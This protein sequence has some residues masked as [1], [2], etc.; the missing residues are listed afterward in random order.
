M[1]AAFGT[2]LTIGGV[3]V[4]ELTSISGS[5]LSM[6]TVD[7]SHHD[8]ADRAREFVAGMIDGGE[9]TMEG[10]LGA[11]HVGLFTGGGPLDCV[12]T[13]PGTAPLLTWAFYG[14]VTAMNCDAPYEGK[15]GF[16]ATM[17]VTGLAVLGAAPVPMA[18]EAAG[19]TTA[20]D[21]T[22]RFSKTIDDTNLVFGDFSYTVNA[23][24]DQSFSAATTLA[25]ERYVE[26]IPAGTNI[27]PGDVVT[28]SYTP[29]T[30]ASNDG[31][32]VAAISDFPAVNSVV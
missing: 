16:S 9:V 19:T 14:Y 23:G 30:L 15:A 20:D 2:T 5:S 25:D 7:V 11:T 32:V 26:L 6:D 17:K 21:I 10:N 8:L 1:S 18:A 27:T 31:V 13:F 28:V 24:V 4:A 3:A 12:I 29:G 22:I